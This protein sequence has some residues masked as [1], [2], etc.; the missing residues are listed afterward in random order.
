MSSTARK[1][2]VYHHL[3]GR[4]LISAIV[5]VSGRP[6]THASHIRILVGAIICDSTIY[7]YIYITYTYIHMCIYIHICIE[8]DVD[9]AY[10][11]TIVKFVGCSFGVSTLLKGQSS[12]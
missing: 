7:I 11:P 1:I 5:S 3:H 2:Y 6:K 12:P 4:Q 9:P 8:P 10:R